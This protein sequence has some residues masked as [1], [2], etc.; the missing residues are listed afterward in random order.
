MPKAKPMISPVDPVALTPRIAPD[1][2]PVDPVALPT[3]IAPE[4]HEYIESI[5][6][7]M[8]DLQSALNSYFSIFIVKK[9]QLRQGDS[10]RPD[11]TIARKPPA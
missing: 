6:K 2:H 10:L 1:E 7:Q 8:D 3:R 11:G 5:R 9:Y 4:H